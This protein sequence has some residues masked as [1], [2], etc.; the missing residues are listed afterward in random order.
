VYGDFNLV[1][2]DA[3]GSLAAVRSSPAVDPDEVGFL[4]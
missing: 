4:P 2:A 1:T 3:V